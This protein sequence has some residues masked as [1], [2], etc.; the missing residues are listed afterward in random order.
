[1]PRLSETGEIGTILKWLVRSGDWVDKEQLIIQIESDKA[2][3][4]INSPTAGT[5]LQI[6]FQEGQTAQAGSVL[7]LL[8]DQG[9]AP[10]GFDPLY[11]LVQTSQAQRPPQPANQSR[12]SRIPADRLTRFRTARRLT[13]H[14]RTNTRSSDNPSTINQ[15]HVNN[16]AREPAINIELPTTGDIESLKMIRRD[17]RDNPRSNLLAATHSFIEV[18]ADAMELASW[19]QH[20]HERRKDGLLVPYYALFTLAVA[21]VLQDAPYPYAFLREGQAQL[22]P[23]INIG[24]V[25]SREDGLIVP[26]I[27]DADQKS[28]MEISRILGKIRTNRTTHI[29]LE[30]LASVTFTISDLSMYGTDNILSIIHQSQ[31]GILFLDRTESKAAAVDD[32]MTVRDLIRMTHSFGYRILDRVMMAHFLIRLE[33]MFEQPAPWAN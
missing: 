23:G 13:S 18:E 11:H 25:V 26:V 33:K 27:R 20:L 8:G 30:A 19:W 15:N 17:T 2:I 22:W 24:L 4:E 21:P 5:V 32:R 31:T 14:G 28:L 6:Y 16:E 3:V 12:T 1:M 10:S 7:A 29:P 9:E